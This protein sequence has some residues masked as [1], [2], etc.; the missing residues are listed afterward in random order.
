LKSSMVTFFRI[1]FTWTSLGE[2]YNFI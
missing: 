2:E 1:F